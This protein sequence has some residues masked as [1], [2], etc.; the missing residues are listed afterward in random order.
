VS[1]SAD[2]RVLLAEG[3]EQRVF[4]RAAVAAYRSNQLV[5]SE[6][7]HDPA[8]VFDVASLTKVLTS[9]LAHQHLKL[10]E[11]LQLLP[12]A[13]AGDLLSHSAGLPAWRPYFAAATRVLGLTL[14]GILSS[15]EAQRA[16]RFIAS[17][18][19]RRDPDSAPAPTY[20]DLGFLL[21]GFAIEAAKQKSLAHVARED[22]FEALEL[23]SMQWGGTHPAAASTG[24]ARPRAGNPG[25]GAAEIVL[26]AGLVARVAAERAY[27]GSSADIV[28]RLEAVSWKVDLS[29]VE[30]REGRDHA[31]DDDN[32]ASM[33]GVVGHAGLWSNAP[34]L[35]KLG[36]A[37]LR[38]ADS[39][40]D[41][42]LPTDTAQ[43]LF[44]R[45]SGSRTLGLDTPSGE[46]PAIG[47]VLGRGPLGAAGHLGFTGCSLWM[48]RDAQLTVALLSNAV[49][50][51]RPNPRIRAF[52]PR[53]QDLI[54][55]A[56][57]G[58]QS[59]PE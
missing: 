58:R 7:T 56:F 49:V 19:A 12:R 18:C 4:E 5:L 28:K 10:N 14:P 29:S 41:E 52:R 26:D 54:A 51:E 2:V 37:L 3:I 45:V 25:V 39:G 30:G 43:L 34:D 35:A 47:T 36:A 23:R 33:G 13:T 48:D 24:A 53:L 6:G 22:L 16:V 57:V 27:E 46:E 44:R 31:V 9:V 42:P 50:I 11:P 38:C 15:P 32:S 1:L 59:K 40:A 20:S 17:C 8:Q 55:K 21:L